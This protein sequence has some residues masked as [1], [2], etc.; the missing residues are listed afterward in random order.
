MAVIKMRGIVVSVGIVMSTSTEKC[1]R[2]ISK[3]YHS[4]YTVTETNTITGALP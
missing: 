2:F 3:Q 1:L 4:F